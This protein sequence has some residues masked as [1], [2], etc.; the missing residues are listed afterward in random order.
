[1]DRICSDY[2]V[3]LLYK[4]YQI[5]RPARPF[6]YGLFSGLAYVKIQDAGNGFILRFKAFSLYPLQDIGRAIFVLVR[7]CM[8]EIQRYYISEHP[9]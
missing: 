2:S 4:K 1:M 8:E 5:K 3:I 6:F 9:I 7:A